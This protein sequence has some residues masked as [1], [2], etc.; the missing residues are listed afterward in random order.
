VAAQSS[1]LDKVL[2][3]V[4]MIVSLLAVG[5]LYFL[6]HLMMQAGIRG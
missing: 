6:F 3:I 1:V 5:G 4:A 2:A